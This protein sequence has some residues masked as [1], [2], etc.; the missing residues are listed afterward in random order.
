MNLFNII[1]KD[2]FKPLV[3]VNKEIYI[4]AIMIIY[5]SYKNELSFGIEKDILIEKLCDYFDEKASEQLIFEDEDEITKDSRSTAHLILRRLKACGWINEETSYDYKVFINLEEY[6][7]SIIESFNMIV[8]D[9]EMEYQSYISSIHSTLANEENYHNPYPRIIISIIKDTKE[10]FS[11]LKNLNTNIKNRIEDI[12]S[13]KTPKE[14]IDDLFKYHNEIGSKAY[15]RIKTGD[16]MSHYRISIIEK[17]FRIL[18]DNNI[19]ALA[20]KGYMEIKKVDDYELASDNLREEIHNIISAFR[21]YDDIEKE[22]DNKHERYLKSS[23][24]RAQFL[25][26]NTSSSKGQISK[27]LEYLSTQLNEDKNSSINDDLEEE[28]SG[29]FNIFPQNYID[30]ESLYVMPVNRRVLNPETLVESLSLSDEERQKRKEIISKKYKNNF[31]RKNINNYVDELLNSQDSILASSIELTNKRDYI[32]LIF[33][34]LYGHNVK[35]KYKVSSKNEIIKKDNF[36]F[37]DFL[38]ERKA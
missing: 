24:S 9:E 18:Q 8:K 16:N 6:A 1:H 30:N 25:L 7:V 34:S 13:D 5:D 26:T 19:F 35:S 28:L 14:I 29:L 21:R 4:D 15:H 23:V 20:I 32:K 22:I 12:S 36:E 2:F 3:G 31:S 27:I 11:G 17:L 33:V 38:I 37:V 10:L